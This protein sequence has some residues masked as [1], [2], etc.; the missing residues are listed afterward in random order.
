M[1]SRCPSR[2][3]TLAA[4]RRPGVGMANRRSSPKEVMAVVVAEGLASVAPTQPCR[5]GPF[6]L[7]FQS[8]SCFRSF[9]S[10]LCLYSPYSHVSRFHTQPHTMT[11]S[12]FLTTMA[13]RYDVLLQV[14]SLFCDCTGIVRC[15]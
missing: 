14:E 11:I 4:D 15:L 6:K 9:S 7:V 13:M 10:C 5:S 2:V 1:L 3:T 12:Q 8:P